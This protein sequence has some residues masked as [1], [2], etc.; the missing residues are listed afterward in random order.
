M[1]PMQPSD[2][3]QL[4]TEL[5]ERGLSASTVR[6]VHIALHSAL[7]HALRLGLVQRNV[8]ELATRPRAEAEEPEPFDEDQANHFV[9]ACVG[10]PYE[11]LFVL[12]I[13]TGMR[14]GELLGVLWQDIDRGK[15]R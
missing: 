10:Y 9:E 6:L 5:S 3:Q 13:T 15:G 12:A 7:K 11:A 8:S 14:Q 1:M 2:A 4:Y